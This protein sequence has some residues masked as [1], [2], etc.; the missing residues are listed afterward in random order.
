MIVKLNKSH[1]ESIK[2]L[3]YRTTKHMGVELT[4]F[5]MEPG[6]EFEERSYEVFCDNYLEDL[7]AFHAYG[8]YD[9]TTDKINALVSYYEAEDDPSWY[10]TVY[11][12]SGNNQ[13]L[14]DVLD[15]VIEVNESAGR[16]KFYTLVNSAHSKLLRRFTWSKYNSERYGWFDEC[17]IPGNTKPY[18]INHWELLFKRILIPTDTTV[19]CNYLKQEYRNAL[20]R[21]GSI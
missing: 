8:Y 15:K 17:I 10:F 6:K 18:F 2:H 21:L 16:L 3:F 12:S 19:R 7:E 9:K 5:T 20:P 13:L 14:K 1:K 4:N 11:R